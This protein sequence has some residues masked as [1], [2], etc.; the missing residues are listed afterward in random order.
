MTDDGVGA[1]ARAA[2]RLR[3]LDLSGCTMVTPASANHLWREG[4]PAVR[5]INVTGA[6]GLSA[7]ALE[8]WFHVAGKQAEHWWLRAADAPPRAPVRVHG[9]ERLLGEPR[10]TSRTTRS[11]AARAP[12]VV[13]R[14]ERV[15]R[16]VR[17]SARPPS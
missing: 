12:R 8:T 9:F 2:P 5:R 13:F 10:P 14:D 1:L 3:A 4:A 7:I 17:K 16:R 6:R 15:Q 11:S